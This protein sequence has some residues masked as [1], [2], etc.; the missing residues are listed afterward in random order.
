MNIWKEFANQTNGTFKEGYSWQSDSVE[1]EY[2]NW[3]I[4]FDNYTLWSGKYST[5][6]TRV[7]VPIILQDNFRFEIYKEGFIRKIE[8]IFGAQDIEIGYADFDKTFTIKSNNEFKIK[9]LLR[10]S[11][12]R[13]LITSQKDV[14]IQ[15]SDQKGIWEEE[16]PENEFELSYFIDGEIRDLNILNELLELFKLILD[17]MLQINV[18]AL[19]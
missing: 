15:I 16:L 3:K 8:K 5:E 6:M 12:I 14:N 7:I 13:N 18:I 17:E 11:E 10:N 1:I 19:K 2:K 4:V 9:T